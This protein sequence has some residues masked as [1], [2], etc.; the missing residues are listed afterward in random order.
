[1]PSFHRRVTHQV[2]LRTMFNSLT[3]ASLKLTPEDKL[4]LTLISI[5]QLSCTC[6]ALRSRPKDSNEAYITF[7]NFTR[8]P[9]GQVTEFMI[10]GLYIRYNSFSG[11]RS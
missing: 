6:L 9:R 8:L 4:F 2:V 11:S 3:S 7:G 5:V 1:V 10:A